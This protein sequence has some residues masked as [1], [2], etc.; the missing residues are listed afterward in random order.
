MLPVACLVRSFGS[1][2]E[3]SLSLFFTGSSL[4]RDSVNLSKATKLKA[5]R[6]W[7]TELRVEWITMA[8]RTITPNH[9]NLRQIFIGI[10]YALSRHGVG[11]NIRQT[12]GE[13]IYERWLD[14]DHLFIQL[15]ESNSIRPGVRYSCT[16]ESEKKETVDCVSCLLPEA[17]KRGIVDLVKH[18]GVGIPM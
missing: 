14:L 5:A 2:V 3:P 15:W 10:P 6:F 17:T 13:T 18:A 8:L 11:A 9:R 4:P 1:R 12:L 16:S 7:C